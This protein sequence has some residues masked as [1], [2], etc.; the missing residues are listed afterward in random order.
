M[1][2]CRSLSSKSN[3]GT[4]TCTVQT[5]A[6]LCFKKALVDKET[7]F[8]VERRALLDAAEM[9]NLNVLQLITEPMATALNYGMFR[10]KEINGT[11]KYMLFYEMGAYDTTAFVVS[12][13][14][15]ML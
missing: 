7:L 9:A 15:P 13:Q 14:G 10:R 12:Y 8:K 4:R 1:K 6:R 2:I 3:A 5:S 11:V